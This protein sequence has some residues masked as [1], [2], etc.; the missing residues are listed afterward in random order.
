MFKTMR[1]FPEQI[2]F[3]DLDNGES[4][5]ISISI[6]NISRKT[7]RVKFL[8]NNPAFSIEQ[9][10]YLSITPGLTIQRDVHYTAFSLNK[11]E[12]T[13]SIISSDEKIEIPIISYPPMPL[14]DVNTKILD[15][16]N[17]SLD[18]NQQ[19]NFILTNFG[20][21]ASNFE[22]KLSN[23][24]ATVSPTRGFLNPNEKIEI[25]VGF[26]PPNPGPYEFQVDI[27]CNEFPEITSM[28]KVKAFV[29]GQ[30]ILILENG[31][32][33]SKIMFGHVFCGDKRKKNITF[34][35]FGPVQRTIQFNPFRSVI[36][37]NSDSYFYP[38]EK[39]YTIEPGQTREIPFF[40]T[41]PK[42]YDKNNDLIEIEQES[43]IEIHNTNLTLEMMLVGITS[44]F[45]TTIYPVDF[46]F[47]K[48]AL[49]TEQTKTLQL[50]NSSKNSV[51]FKIKEIAGF[52]FSPSSGI[53][54]PNSIRQIDVIFRPSML[55]I[56]ESSVSISLCDGFVKK[57]LQVKAESVKNVSDN[58][59]FRRPKI[60]E[61]N[62]EAEFNLQ[63]PNNPYCMTQSEYE[64]KEKLSLTFRDYI[65]SATNENNMKTQKIT[66]NEKEKEEL[67]FGFKHGEGLKPPEPHLTN[68][69]LIADNKDSENKYSKRPLNNNKI[70]QKPTTKLEIAECSKQL[71]QRQLLNIIHSADSIDFGAVTIYGSASKTFTIQN[72]LTQHLFVSFSKF[73]TEFAKSSPQSQV[74]FPQKTASFNLF[75]EGL[76]VGEYNQ[77]LKC[78]I[79][80]HHEFIISVRAKIVPVEIKMSTNELQFKFEEEQ[81]LSSITKQVVV[82]NPTTAKAQLS[83]VGLNDIFSI[84]PSMC[85]CNP[86]QDVHFDVTYKPFCDDHNELRAILNVTG[87]RQQYLT[88]MGETGNTSMTISTDMLDFGT[89][90]IGNPKTMQLLLTSTGEFPSIFTISPCF[91]EIYKINPTSGS[92]YPG[93]QLPLEV[94]VNSMEEISF[95]TPITIHTCGIQPIVFSIRGN[96]QAPSVSIDCEG[97]LDFGEIFVGTSVSKKLKITNKGVVPAIVWLRFE[98]NQAF[99]LEYSSIYEPNSEKSSI[100][101]LN[102]SNYQFNVLENSSV[103]FELVFK[104][105]EPKDYSMKSLPFSCENIKIKYT[106]NLSLYAYGKIPPIEISDQWLDFGIVNIA[107][108]LN[109]NSRP[110]VRQL[111]LENK[112]RKQVRFKF[113]TSK[114]TQSFSVEPAEGV[115]NYSCSATVFVIFKPTSGSIVDCFLPLYAS[116]D[117]GTFEIAQIQLTG[118]IDSKQIRLSQSS[119]CFPVVP[120]NTTVSRTIYVDNLMFITATINV[121]IPLNEKSFPLTYELPEGNEINH[122]CNKLPIVFTFNSPKPMSFSTQVAVVDSLG[123]TCTFTI[124]ATADC[125]VVTL[126]TF[127]MN[128]DCNILRA[129]SKPVII[130]M[131]G[132]DVENDYL[133]YYTELNDIGDYEYNHKILDEETYNFVTSFLNSYVLSTRITD[134][135]TDFANSDGDKLIEV[136]ENLAG[137]KKPNALSGIQK[138]KL[139]DDESRIN[140]IKALLTLLVSMGC[141]VS[142][143]NPLYLTSKTTFLSIMKQNITRML[144]ADRNEFDREKWRDTPLTRFVNSEHFQTKLIPRMK[145]AKDIFNYISK[146]AWLEVLLQVLKVFYLGKSEGENFSLINGVSDA[147]KSIASINVFEKTQKANLL[148]NYMSHIEAQLIKWVS[149][150]LCKMTGPEQI[151]CIFTDLR[152]PMHLANLILSHIPSAK[153]SLVLEPTTEKDNIENAK[154]VAKFLTNLGIGIEITANMIRKGS[155]VVL[156]LLTYQLK[157]SLP[158]FIPTSTVWFETELNTDH[159][160]SITI[161]N[162]GQVEINYLPKIKGCKNFYVATNSLSIKPGQS[163]ECVV[164]YTART[165]S[166]ETATLELTPTRTKISEPKSDRSTASKRFM[167]SSRSF[168]STVKEDIEPDKQAAPASTIVMTLKSSVTVKTP[169]VSLNVE[170]TLYEM[171]KHT[172]TIPN[173]CGI[174]GIY[175]GYTL[176]M[177]ISDE[178]GNPL[179]NVK[180]DEQIIKE[181]FLN[182]LHSREIDSNLS[183]LEQQIEAHPCFLF[184]NDEFEFGTFDGKI[185]VDFYPASLGVFRCYMLFC[186]K[187]GGEF[188][189][190]ILGKSILPTHYDGTVPI[191]TEATVPTPFTVPIEQI[192]YK[193]IQCISTGIAR[194]QTFKQKISQMKLN[195]MTNA[196]SKEVYS[197]YIKITHEMKFNVTSSTEVVAVP[198]EFVYSASDQTFE[199]TFKPMKPGRYPAK[200]VLVHKSFDV[201]II[202]VDGSAFATTKNLKMTIETTCGRQVVQEI[203]FE[204]PASTTWNFKVT[205]AQ[206]DVFSCDTK[207]SVLPKSTFNFPIRFLSKVVG[208]FSTKLTI[209]NLSKE[210]T[211]VLELK[212]DVTEPL[213]ED[214]INI[215]IRAR[216][217]T[218]HTITIPRF[219]DEGVIDVKSDIPIIDFPSSFTIEKENP[220]TSFTFK[221][222]SQVM[223]HHTGTI[224]FTDRLTKLYCW[225][226]IEVEALPPL[227]SLKFEM[228]TQQ[229]VPVTISIPVSN[230]TPEIVEFEVLKSDA[231]LIGADKFIVP[232]KSESKYDISIFPFTSFTRKSSV[233]FQSVLLGTFVYEIDIIVDKPNIINLAPIITMMGKCAKTFVSLTNESNVLANFNIKNGFPEAFQVVADEGQTIK[234]ESGKSK[235]VEIR[236]IPTMIGNQDN[237]IQFESEEIGDFIYKL[238][239]VGKPPQPQSPMI[240]ESPIN[241]MNSGCIYFANPFPFKATFEASIYSEVPGTFQFLNRRRTFIL[242]IFQEQ[243]QVSFS[244]I[245][246]NFGQFSG[247][248][249]VS[250]IG[251]EQNVAWKFPLIGITTTSIGGSIFH[252]STKSKIPAVKEFNFFLPG[253]TENFD[254]SS[255]KFIL[256]FDQ[257]YSWLRKY[258]DIRP[259]KKEKRDSGYFIIADCLY[260]PRRPLETSSN[261]MIEN[262]LGQKWSFTLRCFATP[263]SIDTKI[264]LESDINCSVSSHVTIPDKFGQDTE[265]TAYFDNGSSYDLSIT[266]EEGIIEESLAQETTFVPTEVIFT[267]KTYGKLTKGVL[268]IDTEE[269]QTLIEIIGKMPDY[270]PPKIATSTYSVPKETKSYKSTNKKRNIIRENIESAKIT[271][272]RSS[273]RRNLFE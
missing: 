220:Q 58:S 49:K 124:S 56:F 125:S 160:E 163:A 205:L 183:V 51:P 111:V 130:S 260:S 128:N 157:E 69:K 209:V 34:K 100:Q 243:S 168:A 179:T 129:P 211:I 222:F 190:E 151:P 2:E 24:Y 72:N 22:L 57:T 131:K 61:T 254:V 120:I 269:T 147:I 203:P 83:W 251:L 10:S 110:T 252:I 153:L 122:Q 95:E 201:R 93:E 115:I 232:A 235:T 223:C 242:N 66:N 240:V 14:F 88:L 270:V 248:I 90:P 143:I 200:I 64:M 42:R 271:K 225:Y 16:G 188:F 79:N 166:P 45:M 140:K 20:T 273:R 207:F 21:I 158:H 19:S 102:L 231:D 73:P 182:P 228:H 173:K 142:R 41:P 156:A 96:V 63:H 265:F 226:V 167:R 126:D 253:E 27:L 112:T 208:S 137:Q 28:I 172:L 18:S 264:F 256:E 138:M 174:Q 212:A 192:N 198:E 227:P 74:I 247:S 25:G 249:V 106:K 216:E 33:T 12:A 204:N 259:K 17:L 89:M 39:E 8:I 118:I 218:E 159:K 35:N 245:S 149:I 191:K 4:D 244:F 7:L 195:E 29:V 99:K 86:N 67:N 257:N 47:G 36:D 123:D 82:S 255:Y 13:L 177:K 62:K 187:E 71:T 175:R 46:D 217:E 68:K 108:Q 113:D 92:L 48:Q 241:I 189:V 76:K 75:M 194:K 169:S 210:S 141:L 266:E 214:H 176:M 134:I 162:P 40:F 55:G 54:K 199:C 38:E 132:K 180:N 221:V 81:E 267:P 272:P 80:N 268:I 171:T 104:P 215:K 5:V 250:S 31:K 98:D 97:F 233:V 44:P 219:V 258:I 136:I 150:H 154:E 109:P 152:N 164:I 101:L 105:T 237:I 103:D 52:H 77:F 116:N 263:G 127:L 70:K 9:N 144:L 161:Q 107:D 50:N 246:S 155:S 197:N 229:R 178:L 202:K 11:E 262:N 239:G 261:L 238:T 114:L 119:I 85:V 206:S 133:S 135:A 53:I 234:V 43:T 3:K 186:N 236:Y 165:H 193:L 117:K 196:I 121:I 65:S 213:A 84:K 224:T 94:T 60:W 170:G 32:E 6:T 1:V 15:L 184:H 78:T 146:V 59:T 230:P 23:T 26:K 139:T 30:S 181:F 185:N 148:S 91:S 145:K 87:G 37:N